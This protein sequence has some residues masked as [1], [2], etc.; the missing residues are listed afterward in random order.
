MLL[1]SE[2]EDSSGYQ[3]KL[4]VNVLRWKSL[5]YNGNKGVIMDNSVCCV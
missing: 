3:R 2:A 5:P 4:R 1:V